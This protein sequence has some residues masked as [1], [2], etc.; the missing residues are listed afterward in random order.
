[1]KFISATFL[2]PAL[3]LVFGQTVF[4][5]HAQ[6]HDIDSLRLAMQSASDQRDRLHASVLMARELLPSEKDSARALL[7]GAAALEHSEELLHQVYYYSAWGLYYWEARD[8]QLSID[9]YNKVLQLQTDPS[10]LFLQVEAANHTGLLYFQ[11][12]VADSARVYL[13]M[14]LDIDTE[15]GNKEGMAKNMYDLSRLYRGENQY[16]LAFK[17]ITESIKLQEEH[18]SSWFLPYQYNVLGITHSALGNRKKAAA[19]YEQSLKHVLE[20]EDEE[21]EVYYYNNMAALWCE[22]EGALDTTFYYARKGLELARS[23]GYA[24]LEVPLLANKGLALLIAGEPADALEYFNEAMESIHQLG[25]PR[26]EMDISHRIGNAHRALGDFEQARQA[27]QR[28]L[29]LAID[30]KSLR[31]QSDAL[32]EMAAMDSLERKYEDFIRH[33]VQGVKLRDSIWNKENR[34]RIAELQIMHETEQKELMIAQLEQREIM[35]LSRQRYIIIFALLFISLLVIALMYLRKSRMVGHQKFI[36]NQQEKEVVESELKAKRMELTGKALSLSKSDQ[37]ITQLKQDIQAVLARSDNKSCDELRSALRLLK[38][39]D[40]SKQLWKDFEGQFN[41]L[42]E[43]F[44]NRLTRRYP[45]LSPAEIRLCAMLRL[46]MSTKDIAE[47]IKRSTRTIEH[48]RTSIRKKMKLQP[49]DNLVQHL[50]N[51]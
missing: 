35:N 11:L 51:L 38:T 13:H 27:Q 37:I 14:A 42:N 36:I 1:V 10:I 41:E 8:R 40:N 20:Q 18:G 24:D 28:S 43:N 30:M 44:I 6:P 12:G 32:L 33:Y 16:E 45:S 25:S 15:R 23:G 31:F 46:Q 26:M 21:G 4:F 29:E 39:K 48:T 50:L 3:L 5:L 19:A 47:M 7:E 22:Q 9:H 2:F 49:N 34:S 17:Y